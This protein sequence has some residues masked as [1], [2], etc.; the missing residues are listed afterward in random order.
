[1]CVK[2][3]L[4]PV[5]LQSDELRKDFFFSDFCGILLVTA[6]SGENERVYR[7]TASRF[8]FLAL[9]AFAV[10]F[11]LTDTAISQPRLTLEKSTIDLGAIYQGD[12]K[13]VSL[14]MRNSGTDTLIISDVS[15]S[16]GCTTVKKPKRDL[17]PFEQTNLEVQYNS[18]GF[19]G[20]VTKLITILSNDFLDARAT[21][22]LKA[23][24]KTELEPV[25]RTYN[26]WFGN[27][28]IDRPEKKQISY[29]NVSSQPLR[30]S[31]AESRSR[32]VTVLSGPMLLQPN[33]T[34]TADLIV[35]ASKAGYGVADF[36]I[37]FES[38]N[39]RSLNMKVTYVGVN[40]Q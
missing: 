21:V 18:T 28:T 33:E 25:D 30:I 13:M 22:T 12:I 14:S 32:D 8:T 9:A 35:T 34:G 7:M 29:K 31:G 38:K 10:F 40:P 6:L 27:V 19:Q 37:N 5:S 39:Q 4:F 2:K 1:L 15:T 24:V 11:R 20:Q 3:L 26:V 16:C 23:L 17:A 36:K